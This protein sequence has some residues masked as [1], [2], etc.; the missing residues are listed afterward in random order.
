MKKQRIKNVLSCIL[1]QSHLKMK[2]SILFVFVSLLQVNAADSYGQNQKVTLSEDGVS[3]TQIFQQIED[4]T[5]LHFFYN[6]KDLDVRQKV[7]VNA[8]KLRVMELL[9]QLFQDKG[10]TYQILGNQIVLKKA[11]VP[12]E[13]TLEMEVAQQR[14]IE[15]IISDQSGMPM[16]GVT[17]VVEG[18]HKGVVSNY[19][20]EYFIT[21]ELANRV[22]VFSSLGYET[23][24]VTVGNENIIDVIMKEDFSQLDEV[25]LIGYGEQKREDVTGAV[26]SIKPE[27]IV[28]AATGSIGFDRA[29]GGLVKGVQV[30]QGSGRP[31]NPE[32]PA[33]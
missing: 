20:G 4:Q 11:G 29:L 6:N 15:G 3:M 18:T 12:L 28:Q 1:N 14:Q 32:H 31:L 21:L 13:P 26:S 5:D 7:S 24:R 19:N 33:G 9:A 30:S 27:N 16:A 23:Q 2:F 10:M 22:L 8:D 17:I 25:V